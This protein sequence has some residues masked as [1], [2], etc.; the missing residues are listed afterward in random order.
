MKTIKPPRLKKGERVGVVAPSQ[1]VNDRLDRFMAAGPKLEQLLGIEFVYSPHCLGEH[2]YSSG[3]RAERLDD[4]HQMIV[5][6]TIKAVFFALGGHTANELLDGIDYELVRDNPKIITGI[7]DCTTLLNPLHAKT[8]LIT[9]HGFEFSSFGYPD[10]RPFETVS[11]KQTFFDGRVGEL[12]PNPSWR[13]WRDTPTSYSGWSTFREGTATGHLIGGN[14]SGFSHSLH[15]PYLPE[16]EGALLFLEAYKFDKRDLHSALTSLRLHGVFDKI[17]G[18]IMGYCVGSDNPDQEYN[19]RPLKDIVLEVT[20]D[21]SFPMMQVGEI[22]HYVE[23]MIIPIGAQ[24][25]I[26]TEELRFTI[27]EE[28]VN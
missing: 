24:A 11:L 17:A 22:G 1:S 14:Y 3:T 7:S 2:Y 21:F 19:Q 25:T 26:D 8:G 20:K 9:F 13:D 5:D 4:F 23:N 6:P 10:S 18:L 27:D 12:H 16:L 28:V 15:T